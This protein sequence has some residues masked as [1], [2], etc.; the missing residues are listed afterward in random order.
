MHL[1][2]EMEKNILG[3]NRKTKCSYEYL[4]TGSKMNG[5]E[6]EQT[7]E[8]GQYFWRHAHKQDPWRD[9]QGYNVIPYLPK[10]SSR[11]WGNTS[12]SGTSEVYTLLSCVP[13]P[14]LPTVLA[15]LNLVDHNNV[16]ED[17]IKHKRKYKK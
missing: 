8:K 11:I 6:L 9:F 16:F 13:C 4:H 1:Q 7:N 10:T 17:V 3:G 2:K 14:S 12:N 15:K 5:V